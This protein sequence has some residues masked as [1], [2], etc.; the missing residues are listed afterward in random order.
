[1]NEKID[2]SILEKYNYKLPY[3]IINEIAFDKNKL[4][5]L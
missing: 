5:E 4:I 1:M 2:E 3:D